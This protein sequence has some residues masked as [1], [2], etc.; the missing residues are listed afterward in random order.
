MIEV[1][2]AGVRARI[3]RAGMVCALRVQVK[4]PV[5]AT[6]RPAARTG[7][8]G[9]QNPAASMPP[10]TRTLGAPK[11]VHMRPFGPPDSA[12]PAASCRLQQGA[13]GPL[14]APGVLPGLLQ[15]QHGAMR[16]LKNTP[17]L[18]HPPAGRRGCDCP[19]CNLWQ[20]AGRGRR[21]TTKRPP[22]AL[23]IE[24]GPRT[25]LGQAA[26][27]AAVAVRP[28][29]FVQA[30]GRR[31]ASTGDSCAPETHTTPARRMRALTPRAVHP[32]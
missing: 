26:T 6:R 5:E 31:V 16:M 32:S 17:A 27:M 4:S 8:P 24:K 15:C 7:T 28:G 2:C 20:A 9:P 23:K 22:A 12:N 13:G 19:A 30:A 21:S 1:L 14:A 10:H 25:S 29:V 18:K 3:L 11:A